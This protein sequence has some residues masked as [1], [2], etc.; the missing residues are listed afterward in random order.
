LNVLIAEEYRMTSSSPDT[1]ELVV[2]SAQLSYNDFA[3][4][5]RQQLLKDHPKWSHTDIT[6]EIAILWAVHIQSPDGN[7]L[8]V[9]AS[10]S[11]PNPT[12]TTVSEPAPLYYSA[13]NF[14]YNAQEFIALKTDQLLTQRL[15]KDP[16]VAN[17]VVPP[18]NARDYKHYA[19]D[20]RSWIISQHPEWSVDQ[21]IQE[22]KRLWKLQ[23]EKIQG[24]LNELKPPPPTPRTPPSAER[25]STA[26]PVQ[27]G[28]PEPVGPTINKVTLPRH[29]TR[30]A[31]ADAARL[32]QPPPIPSI[33]L[34]LENPEPTASRDVDW[35]KVFN[36]L[37]K[38]LPPNKTEQDVLNAIMGVW[39]GQKN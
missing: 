33:L 22:T 30:G 5:M 8:P 6:R 17:A 34:K 23:E 14:P 38:V 15:T 24:V 32:A 11:G 37:P 35:S 36:A 20:I 29:T 12:P 10:L 1:N 2:E 18:S 39:T 9:S 27:P 4:S 26:P 25:R 28:P 19:D 16:S 21:I 7:L 13:T 31:R 3:K